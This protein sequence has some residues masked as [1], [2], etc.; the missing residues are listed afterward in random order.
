[1]SEPHETDAK[2]AA[3]FRGMEGDIADAGA[4]A[5]VAE[6]IADNCFEMRDPA[7]LARMFGL[8]QP[9]DGMILFLLTEDQ[10]I[11][12]QYPYWASFVVTPAA[13]TLL[14]G[15]YGVRYLGI[16]EAERQCRTSE[17]IIAMESLWKRKLQSREMG[18][19]KN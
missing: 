5:L 10:D 12:F 16:N 18:L 4:A 6:M 13:E 8:R 15:F 19:N 14:A 3:A 7:G 9:P 2:L 17:E 11:A 1:M